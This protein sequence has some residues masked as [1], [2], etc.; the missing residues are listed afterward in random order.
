MEN[1]RV[2]ASVLQSAA[3]LSMAML[4]GGKHTLIDIYARGNLLKICLRR[5]GE[6][7]RN[8]GHCRKAETKRNDFGSCPHSSS[9]LAVARSP[10]PREKVF[11]R[12]AG[13][14]QSAANLSMAMLAGGKHSLSNCSRR[15][16]DHKRTPCL[17][18]WERCPVRTLG[19]EGFP[20]S[21][22]TLPLGYTQGATFPR[23][24]ATSGIRPPR[25]DTE[26]FIFLYKGQ[27]TN[28][29]FLAS[30][31]G[32]GAQCAHWAERVLL[33]FSSPAPRSTKVLP[34]CP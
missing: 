29:P 30:P 20:G 28:R 22:P 6:E 18:L 17:S 13:V 21:S 33:G 19:G 7:R 15:P 3:N 32:R 25:N 4:A 31:L 24:I 26:C 14:L 9:D 16:Y 27:F 34:K 5:A 10:S 1:Y 2:I 11:W 12:R 23:E 8:A